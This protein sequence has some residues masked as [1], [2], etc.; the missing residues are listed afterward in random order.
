MTLP[1]VAAG[2]FSRQRLGG[3]PP[4]DPV[5][6]ITS[7]TG[8]P[9]QANQAGQFGWEFKT[10][11]A[12]TLVGFRVAL[13]TDGGTLEETV[14]LWRVSDETLLASAAVNSNNDTWVEVLLDTPVSLADD[15]NYVVATR[16]TAG[17]TRRVRFHTAANFSFSALVSHV[18]RRSGTT[19]GF[20]SST[21]TDVSGF[22]D[23]L[24]VP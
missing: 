8:T 13:G 3:A 20:P 2:I 19:D 11:Q 16:R 6:L 18:Q 7:F 5:P 15:A 14:R 23:A 4:A 10:N 21:S 17:G 24:V 22:A 9:S 1:L 12:L